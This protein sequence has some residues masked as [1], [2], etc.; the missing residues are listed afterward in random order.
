MAL[1]LCI[2]SCQYKQKNSSDNIAK[3]RVDNRM[4]LISTTPI[5]NQGNNSLCWA[6]AMLATLESEHIMRGDSVNLSVAYV[7]RMMLQEKAIEYYL[8]KARKPICMRGMAPM[9]L[10][11][12]NKYGAIP[13]DSYEDQ[14]ELDMRVLC[15]KVEYLC[16][17][18]IAQQI[19]ITELKNRLNQLFDDTMGCL[20]AHTV[21]MLGAEYTPT[22]FAHSICSP[23]EYEALTSFTHHPFG[24]RFALETPDN[25]TGATFLNVPIDQLMQYIRKAIRQGH[26]VCWEGD[27]SEPGFQNPQQG[28]VD[29][30]PSQTPVTQASRQREFESLRTTDDHVMEIIGMFCKNNHYYYVCRNSWGKLWGKSG[31]IYLSENYIRLKTIAVIISREML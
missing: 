23:N 12:I 2:C 8:S 9:L 3:E 13:Y 18:A 27:I 5:K 15:R 25:Q 22:E 11:Y 28:F 7:T 10:H 24:E 17:N 26:P 31:N 16:R 30:K 19:G 6:Y 21:H 29:V 4:Q 14:E 20:P 1:L